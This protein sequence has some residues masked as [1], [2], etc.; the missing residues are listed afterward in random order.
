M[1]PSNYTI[2]HP[3]LG[4]SLRGKASPIS[5]QFRNLKYASV[6]ARYKESIPHDTLDAG[7]DGGVY[8]TK[9]GPSCPQKRGAQAWDLTLAGNVTLPCE[10][11]QGDTERMD[12]FD[13]LHVNVTV[14]KSA[15]HT[16]RGGAKDLPVFVWVHGGGLSMGS[17]SWP[18]YDLRKFVE[19]S[20]EI[21]KPVI[22]VAINYRL[23][24]WGFAASRELGTGGNM[25]F[26][27]QILA[28]QWIKRHIAGFGGDPDNVT[29]AGESAGGIS[30]STLL[31]ANVGTEGLFE[32][33]I[34]MSG[35]TNLR[36][37]RNTW[38]HEQMYKD[39]AVFLA[40][41]AADTMSLKKKLLHTDVDALAQQ[42]PLAQH[43]CAHIDGEWLEVDPTLNILANGHRSEHKPS[44]C[45]EF[46][47]GDTA[48]DGTVL[49]GRILDHPDALNRLKASCNRYLTN[50]D[51]E[52]LLSAYKLDNSLSPK[53]EKDMLR[54]LVSELRFY[55]PARAVH[56]GWKST[57]PLKKAGR[58]HF[59]V[60]N[61]FEGDFEGISSHELDVTFLLQNFNH[62][63]GDR[64]RSAAKSMADHFI[65]FVN[66]EG[67]ARD[68]KIVVFGPDG[69][70]EIDEEEYDRLYRDGRGSLLESIGVEKL[71]KVADTWQ[72]VRSEDDERTGARL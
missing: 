20:E 7:A 42:L 27:D 53:Q 5:V 33:V 46:V 18:Q 30:L 17:N 60:L 11:G 12:E 48:H 35:E 16:R 8:A 41:K 21:G 61:P 54:C 9:F 44:W 59:H 56:K 25:G 15:L 14:P 45:K 2:R 13:C 29:A 19:R 1:P 34:I 47:I 49:K 36:K 67:W 39:Q 10:P 66:G 3:T 32:R 37:P 71:W 4:C 72:G 31:C 58:Y 50:A 70:V 28:F 68:G 57:S 51:T 62:L 43:H 64:D 40:S 65:K 38:W 22:G 24:L 52:R 69:V 23:G 26:K 55:A 63:L 6:P